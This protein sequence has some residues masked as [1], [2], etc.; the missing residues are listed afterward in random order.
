MPLTLQATLASIS[1]HFIRLCRF[2]L[3][4]SVLPVH[5]SDHSQVFP[6]FLL[7]YPT[8]SP[9]YFQRCV[10][11]AV[12]PP[13]DSL[14]VGSLIPLA[15]LAQRTNSVLTSAAGHCLSLPQHKDVTVIL[16]GPRALHDDEALLLNTSRIGG[17]CLRSVGD[18]IY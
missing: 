7:L 10:D 3:P 8:T 5:P 13:R 16:A 17:S 2:V 6:R 12:T 11:S 15:T 1:V 9:F 14:P 4:D 18:V